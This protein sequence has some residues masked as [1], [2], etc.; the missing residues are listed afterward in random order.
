VKLR[1]FFLSSPKLATSDLLF[2]HQ[3]KSH[4]SQFSRNIPDP[5]HFFFFF[6]FVG[7]AFTLFLLSLSHIVLI[8]ISTDSLSH[9]CFSDS[10]SPLLVLEFFCLFAFWSYEFYSSST[11]CSSPFWS[12]EFYSS[13]TVASLLQFPFLFPLI[14]SKPQDSPPS[15]TLQ[16]YV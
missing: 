16:E 9:V 8:L 11:N 14:P 12:Y 5:A 1:Y 4:A 13:S 6:F 15:V 3:S 2:P 7:W 10:L